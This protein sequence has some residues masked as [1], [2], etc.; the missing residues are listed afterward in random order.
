MVGAGL[1]AAPHFQA[2]AELTD[3]IDMHGVFTRSPEG[4]AQVAARWGLPVVARFEDLLADDA[5]GALLVLTP[6]DQRRAIA[7]AAVRAGKAVLME[8]PLERDGAAA[9]HIV[10]LF[11]AAG[12]PLG[13]VF[14]HRFRAGAERLRQLI[15]D[16]TLGRIASVSVEVPW[17]RP[18]SYYDQPGRGSLAR[19]GGGVLI[20]QAIHIL[21]LMLSL[22]GPVAEVQAMAGTT[23]HHMEC[24][25]FAAAALRFE[26]GALGALMAT[27]TAAPGGAERL[28][29]HCTKAVARIEAGAL[30]VDYH[31][32]RAEELG[33][34]G[35]SGSGADPMAFDHGPHRELIR[36]FAQSV[37]GARALRVD[38]QAGLAVQGLI[39]AIM[40]SSAS[41]RREQVKTF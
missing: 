13:V 37:L 25:D 19:D 8:K 35:G 12:L 26:G 16:G 22:T 15:E 11:E 36:D 9:A 1:A 30:R 21:D 10:G 34:E 5:I 17:W 3:V 29:L 32:G 41:G 33:L 20:T 18:Q 28:V 31:D 2:L 23:L 38:G 7:E 40:R 27:T 4:R 39:D 14:Q 24:E 6:P